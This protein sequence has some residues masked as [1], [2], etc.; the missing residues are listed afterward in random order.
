MDQPGSS[1]PSNFKRKLVEEANEPVSRP[2]KKARGPDNMSE[3]GVEHRSHWPEYFEEVK[4]LATSI[5]TFLIPYS[6]SR[7]ARTISTGHRSLTTTNKTFKALNTVLAFCSSRKHLA[8]TFSVIRKSAESL[9]KRPIDLKDVAEVK[10]VIPDLLRFGYIPADQVRLNSSEDQQGKKRASS[11]TYALPSASIVDDE[12]HVLVFEFIESTKKYK[13]AEPENSYSVPPSM[14]AAQLK[15]LIEERNIR[16]IQAVNELIEACPRDGADGPVELVKQAARY[17]IPVK[18][19]G[20]VQQSLVMKN[21]ERPPMT[22]IIE[23][24]R[25]EDWYR[26][27]IVEHRSLPRKVP[28][29]GELAV[30]LPENVVEALQ[31]SRGISKLYKHQADAINAVKDGKHVIVCTAT[32]SGKSVIYQV[33]ALLFLEEDNDSTA[34]Y[35]YPTKALAQDQRLALDQLV[36]ACPG[37]EDIKVS[38]YDG[39]TPKEKRPQIRESAS[40]IF[41]NFVL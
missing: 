23:E 39:D 25:R 20:D 3:Q 40:V 10:A 21:S 22:E 1:Q 33:P 11:P 32:A 12:D 2:S 36:H 26:D 19:K 28:L 9:L 8:T 15:K 24:L 4:Q 6:F 17:H 38:T 13:S 7:R 31:K 27:Q 41:T 29:I 16:F 34:I 14:T 18:A 30:P 37:L 5:E 35:I